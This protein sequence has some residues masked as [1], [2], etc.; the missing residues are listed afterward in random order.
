MSAP[1]TAPRSTLTTELARV[2]SP[3]VYGVIGATKN[4]VVCSGYNEV[5]CYISPPVMRGYKQYPV[6][7]T[8]F[9]M[10][11]IPHRF[12]KVNTFCE[13][14]QSQRRSKKIKVIKII[15]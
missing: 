2:P 14:F 1:Q 12:T 4:P 6:S 11:T 13:I 8:H 9:V 5:V 15:A 7:A 10:D 3:L